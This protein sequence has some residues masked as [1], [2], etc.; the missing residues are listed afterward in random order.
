MGIK[1]SLADNK[2][3]VMPFP[4][5]LA[6][7]RGDLLWWDSANSLA[8]KASQRTDLGSLVLNQIDFAQLFLGVAQDQRLATETDANAQRTVVTD[9]IFDCACASTTW[10]VG[11]FVGVDRDATPLN[12]NQQVAKVTVPQLAIGVCVKAGT[13][14]TTVR[15]RL[16]SRVGFIDF[17]K[18]QRGFGGLQGVGSTALGDAN[19]TLTVASNPILSMVPTAARNVTLPLEAQSK[20]LIFVF[21]NNS[22]GAFSVTFKASDGAT[23]IKGNGVVP[24]NKTGYFWCDG[25]NWNGLVSA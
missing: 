8:K 13:N 20:E 3:V 15:A 18:R 9:G 4:A 7:A 22:A 19:Q 1:E 12:Y 21:T 25:T 14:L 24:Q 16:T 6:I 10:A 2:D 17:C 11:D 23:A 5:S